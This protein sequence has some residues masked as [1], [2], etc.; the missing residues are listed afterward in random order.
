MEFQIAQQK[1]FLT[2]DKQGLVGEG[3]LRA[4]F[5]YA[6]PGDLIRLDDAERFGL[7][8]GAL[9]EAAPKPAVAPKKKPAAKPETKPAPAPEVKER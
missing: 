8:D 5:L 9:P 2:A 3:D 4:A 7:I 1:L 6:M